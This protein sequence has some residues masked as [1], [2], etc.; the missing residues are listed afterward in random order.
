MN[1][2]T[3]KLTDNNLQGTANINNDFTLPTVLICDCGSAEHQIIIHKDKGFSEGY[4]EVILCPHLITH[5]NIFKRILIAIKYIFGYKCKY[6]AWDSLIVS[7]QNYLPLKEVV[8]FLD[9]S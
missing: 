8:E 3:I 5:R 4:R 6:G 9:F 7:K 2:E 1:D